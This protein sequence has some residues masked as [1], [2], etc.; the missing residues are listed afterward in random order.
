MNFDL[1]NR[2]PVQASA[3]NATVSVPHGQKGIATLT[4]TVI[5]L[6]IVTL[7]V[8][9]ATRVGLLDLRM[10]GN[11]VRYK[12]AFALAEAGLDFATQRFNSEFK[13]LYDGT[14][15]ATSLSAVLANSQIGTYT[16]T[17]GLSPGT[18]EGYFTVQITEETNC[19]PVPV[20]PAICDI[21]PTSIP[22]Y[23]FTSTGIGPDGTGTATITRQITMSH[24]LG[25]D[26]VDIPVVVSGAVGSGGNFNVVA[27]PNGAGRGVPV[28]VWTNNT[29][30]ANGSSGTCHMQYF[31]YSISQ[32][33]PQSSTNENLT[34]GTNPATEITTYSTSSPDLLPNDANFPADLFAFVFG[35][36]RSDWKIKRNE[37]II[38]GQSVAS[39][40][41]IQN[42][43]TSAGNKFTLWWITGDCSL[44]SGTEIG[45]DSKPVILVVD[46][47][48]L[49][50]T[51][52]ATIHGIVYL[53]DNPDTV[54][55]PTTDFVGTALVQGS[56]ISDVGGDALDGNFSVVYDPSVVNSFINGGGSNFTLAYI[57]GSWRDF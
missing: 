19:F 48:E 31:N 39:C 23:T 21:I 30:S 33:N 51:G 40:T 50:T 45:T 8:F 4:V 54:A 2:L 20:P 7:M 53:F 57:P 22:V 28:S 34:R 27:N 37:A 18:G 44:N 49:S 35:I 17:G 1:R 55:T 10:A 46:D 38:N 11:E 12:E 47:G 3:V 15:K 32:C 14:N 24:A 56:F 13:S 29:I 26:V 25:G 41:P 42:L 16:T 6:V 5:I 36:P 52:S 43:G 9:F